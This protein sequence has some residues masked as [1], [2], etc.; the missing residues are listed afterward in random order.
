MGRVGRAFWSLDLAIDDPRW[1]VPAAHE[2]AVNAIQSGNFDIALQT[3]TRLKEERTDPGGDE[4][5]TSL[6]LEVRAYLGTRKNYQEALEPIDAILDIDPGNEDALRL[7]AAAFLGLKRTDE[8]YELIRKT[9][10]QSEDTRPD[11]EPMQD[12]IYWC[13]VESSFHLES[14]DVA[15]AEEVLEERLEHFPTSLALIDRALG[16]YS[17]QG[18]SAAA[19]RLLRSAYEKEP[20][21]REFRFPL[22]LQLRAI[23]NVQ[24]AEMLLRSALEREQALEQPNLAALATAWIDLAGFLVDQGRLEDG[25]EAY[26]EV[27]SLIGTAIPPDL[28]FSEAEAMIRAGRYDDALEIADETPIEVHRPMIRGRV[29]FEL[30]ALE[31]ALAEFD[32]AALIWPDNAPLRYYLARAAEGLG[33]FDRAVEE[34]RQAIRSDQDLTAARV[35]LG[36]L[37]LAEGRLLQAKAIMRFAPPSKD[38]G[39]SVESKLIQIEIQARTGNA[40]DLSDIPAD[41]SLS[42]EETYA[43][44]TRALSHGFRGRNGPEAAARALGKLQEQSQGILADLLFRERV[45]SLLMAGQKDEALM[46]SRAAVA[47]RPDNVHARIALARSL[48]RDLPTLVEA[49]G[50][51][52][53]AAKER[54]KDAEVLAWLGEVEAA[55]GEAGL[56]IQH[57]EAALEIAPDHET[58]MIGLAHSLDSLARRPEAVSR[59]EEFLSRYNPISGPAA[60]VLAELLD[61]DDGTRE[62]RITLGLRALRFGGGK[63]A[64]EF[65]RTIDPGL[66]PT[67]GVGS[68][69]TKS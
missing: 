26:A 32:Q 25:I 64:V 14:G 66:F 8:A 69:S 58:A 24:E 41:P 28:L 17:S 60:L 38:A 20:D 4:D 44:V 19:L 54:P 16:I 22:V 49:R 33:N 21:N 46:L 12:E 56:A 61:E 50:L 67:D 43:L 29:A 39:P 18:K 27:R 7:K 40:P 2:L 1:M 5:L 15:R 57:F 31:E 48:G 36:K 52:L 59:L 62:Q 51:L 13:S 3:L 55:S 42:A 65:L 63:P 37:H 68:Q 10:R 11:G 34:Y 53:D 47:D 9:G 45:D 6:F 30:G 35:R 23:G